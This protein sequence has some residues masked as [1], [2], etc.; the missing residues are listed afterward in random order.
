[1]RVS[2]RSSFPRLQLPLH[3]K[4]PLNSETRS[5]E[6]GKARLHPGARHAYDP[7]TQPPEFG[8]EVRKYWAFEED[9]VNV[10]R[11]EHRVNRGKIW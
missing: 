8:E 1:M 2:A 7:D 5:L 9:Y 11:G 6:P 4:L 3:T 10:N